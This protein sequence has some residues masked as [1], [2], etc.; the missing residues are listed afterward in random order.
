MI[1]HSMK[2]KERPWALT[3]EGPFMKLRKTMKAQHP[4]KKEKER[5]NN[6]NN[7]K[8]R[9]GPRLGQARGYVVRR[10]SRP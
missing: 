6:N 8:K 3:K 5:N 4:K 9:R 1:A 2:N 7:K 10:T